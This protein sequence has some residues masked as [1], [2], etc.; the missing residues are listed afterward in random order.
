VAD[1]DRSWGVTLSATLHCLAGCANGEVLGMV[2]G[3]A[4]DLSDGLTVAISIVLAFFFGYSADEP[5]LLR[6]GL[7]LSAVIPIALAPDTVSIAI[8]EF[9]DN[10]IML[11]IPGAMDASLSDPGFWAA[12]AAALVIAGVAALP[13]NPL[14]H[15]PG[16]GAR[17]DARASGPL[18]HGPAHRAS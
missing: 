15:C 7:A 9:V 14:V 10:G 8:M 5:A 17:G 4:A 11:L 1:R 12:L 2:I 16:A 13:V 6:S 3:N 18:I